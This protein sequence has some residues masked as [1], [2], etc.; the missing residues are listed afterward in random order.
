MD[1][2]FQQVINNF[3]IEKKCSHS[4]HRGVLSACQYEKIGYHR[5]SLDQVS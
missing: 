4:D 3:G 2:G 1:K 5:L